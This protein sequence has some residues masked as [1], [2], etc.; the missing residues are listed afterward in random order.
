VTPNAGEKHGQNSEVGEVVDLALGPPDPILISEHNVWP[1]TT[2]EV[3]DGHV[4]VEREDL[5]QI[6]VSLRAD[7]F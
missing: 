6:G 1:T 2:I 7:L 5:R 4:D 3:G